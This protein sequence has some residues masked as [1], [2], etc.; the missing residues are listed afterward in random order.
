MATV[1]FSLPLLLFSC[2]ESW[3]TAHLVQAC[4]DCLRGP[5]A[6]PSVAMRI[7]ACM[8]A[9]GK[10]GRLRL[11][12]CPLA[13]AHVSLRGLR[14]AAT[15][16]HVAVFGE[17]ELQFGYE[18]LHPEVA[19]SWAC[20]LAAKLLA[21]TCRPF[22]CTLREGHTL[23]LFAAVKASKPGETGEPRKPGD[24]SEPGETRLFK[25]LLK[26]DGDHLIAALLLPVDA[27]A[28]SVL[29]HGLAHSKWKDHVAVAK[30]TMKEMRTSLAG[31]L[32]K[33]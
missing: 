23:V 2:T 26:A 12:L 29:S 10:S 8:A 31:T 19:G 15:M 22:T 3:R 5:V 6:K 18:Q 17:D 32:S 14:E 27:N 30:L 25:S 4:L 9:T 13:R 21:S 28:E 20:F 7:L 16:R 11:H 1:A 24:V 33:T